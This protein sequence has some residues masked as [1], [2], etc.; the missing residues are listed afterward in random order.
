MESVDD[1]HTKTESVVRLK[2]GLGAEVPLRIERVTGGITNKLFSVDWGEAAEENKVLVRHF[3]AEGMID[4][5]VEN[6]VFAWLASHGVAPPLKGLFEGGRIEGWLYGFRPLALDEMPLVSSGIAAQMARL[7]TLP[8]ADPDL[9]ARFGPDAPV[10]VWSD[11]QSWFDQA[12]SAER[13]AACEAEVGSDGDESAQAAAKLLTAEEKATYL[14]FDFD[15]FARRIDALKVAILAAHAEGSG[16][17]SSSSSS[18]STAFCHN[19]ILCNNVMVRPALASGGA[20][21][22]AGGGELEVRLIDFEYGG[23]N[24]CAFDVANHLNEWAG[25]SLELTP[26]ELKAGVRRPGYNGTM[27]FAVR[28]ASPDQR[29]AFCSE[30]LSA[31]SAARAI[32]TE[33]GG[34]CE[35]AAEEPA[36]APATAPTMPIMFRQV[37]DPITTGEEPSEFPSEDALALLLRRVELFIELNH[38]YWGVWAVNRAFEEG[39]ASFD[40]IEY[41]RSRFSQIKI[42]PL[43]GTEVRVPG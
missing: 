19:D 14:S 8:L 42:T 43:V 29:R 3:G 39:C 22:S 24:Y 13:R 17:G 23:S 2:L 26:A 18:S 37:T 11:L 15:A 31:A 27:D 1:L 28:G 10:A 40:F 35:D 7:H 12:R 41:C 32:S 6:R 25:G 36:L 38:A 20:A 33:K 34:D 5:E 9:A 30:Y 16:G 4:R 21:E